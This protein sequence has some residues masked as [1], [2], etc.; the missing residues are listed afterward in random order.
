MLRVLLKSNQFF[1]SRN[2]SNA[3]Q[4]IKGLNREMQILEC[5]VRSV[6][7]YKASLGPIDK[8]ESTYNQNVIYETTSSLILRS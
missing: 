6:L 2:I 4:V 7:L 1:K 8:S 5:I 3:Y